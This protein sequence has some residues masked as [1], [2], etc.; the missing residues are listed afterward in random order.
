LE[1]PRAFNLLRGSYRSCDNI[2]EAITCCTRNTRRRLH[3][4]LH[5]D[6]LVLRA[7]DIVSD[8]P[9]GL[10]ELDLLE[11]MFRVGSAVFSLAFVEVA[12]ALE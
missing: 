1:L 11:C 9:G 2:D 8:V 6:P 3:D 10:T 5:V 4:I 12:H 7:W